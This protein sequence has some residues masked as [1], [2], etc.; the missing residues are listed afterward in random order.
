MSEKNL[1]E[2]LPDNIDDMSPEQF[3]AYSEAVAKGEMQVITPKEEEA[4]APEPEK[5]ETEVKSEDEPEKEEDKSKPEEEEEEDETE[6]EELNNKDDKKSPH[7]PLA[8]WNK[9]KT[10]RDK[11]IEDL[12]VSHQK[13][14]EDL[15]NSITSTSATHKSIETDLQKFAE[16]NGIENTDVIKGLVELI[17]KNAPG[18]DP[19]TKKEIAEW[20]ETQRINAE[21]SAFESDFNKTAL[22][23]LKK[24]NPNLDDAHLEQAKLALKELAYKDEYIKLPLDKVIKLEEK[25]F[26]FNLEKKKTVETSRPGSQAG[27]TIQDFD[28]WTSEDI[29]NAS[30]EDFEKYSNYMA[31]KS[32]S[33]RK[34]LDKDGNEVK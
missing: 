15:K 25:K 32:G 5:K 20:K 17:T 34:V 7:V 14:I 6:E 9:Y 13:E 4:N 29:D 16:E 11:E 23:T 26:L 30:P 28:S 8:K 27:T 22:P 2:G 24:L 18:L 19:E 3:G 31:S 12:K 33:G 1:L 10:K 21:N